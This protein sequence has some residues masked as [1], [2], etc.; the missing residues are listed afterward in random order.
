MIVPLLKLI[1]DIP[2]SSL[3][4]YKLMGSFVPQILNLCISNTQNT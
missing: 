3:A 1:I 2:I 4:K